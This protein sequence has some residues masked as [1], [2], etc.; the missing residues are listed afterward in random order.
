MTTEEESEARELAKRF[1]IR[2][3]DESGNTHDEELYCFGLEDI[4]DLKKSVESQ[5]QSAN[6]QQIFTLFLIT[7]EQCGGNV[8]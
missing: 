4:V 6:L 8:A 1:G 7:L 3:C 5:K 2:M